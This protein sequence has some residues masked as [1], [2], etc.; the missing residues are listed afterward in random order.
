MRILEEKRVDH[1]VVVDA[2][3]MVIID[4]KEQAALG[5]SVENLARCGGDSSKKLLVVEVWKIR[6]S[7]GK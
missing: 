4:S 7:K 1:A 3:K 6:G 2:Q 5:L